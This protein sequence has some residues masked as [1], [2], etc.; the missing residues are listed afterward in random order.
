MVKNPSSG[1]YRLGIKLVELG[2]L[3]VSRD[4]LCSLAMPILE[5][6][7]EHTG[8]TIQLAIPD[9]AEVLYIQRMETLRVKNVIGKRGRRLPLH[10]TSCGKILAAHDP[11]L[12][13]ARIAL[14]FPPLT[15]RT[16]TDAA[17]FLRMLRETRD[18]GYAVSADEAVIGLASVSARIYDRSH[19]VSASLSLVAPTS[20]LRP[21]VANAARLVYVAGKRLSRRLLV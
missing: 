9:R 21:A 4:R 13:D 2:Q 6:V 18:N 11:L 12:A 16:V 7:R 19:R 15:T 1:R 10:A 3:A 17:E 8:D 14:G 20:R 5:E